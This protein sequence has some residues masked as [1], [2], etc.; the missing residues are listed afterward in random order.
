MLSISI[1]FALL[2]SFLTYI[3]IGYARKRNIIDIPN[4]RSSHTAPTPRGGGVSIVITF[5]LVVLYLVYTFS[6]EPTLNLWPLLLA[7]LLIAFIGF[8]DDNQHVKFQIRLAI[9][10][11]A[12]IGLVLAYGVPT[13]DLLGWVVDTK[14]LMVVFVILAIVWLT[15]LYNFMDGINGIASTEAISVLLVMG[16]LLTGVSSILSTLCFL[17]AFVIVGFLPWNFPRAKVFMGD[18]GSGF[19]GFILAALWLVSSIFD[20]RLFWCW[21]IMLGV[22]IVDSTIT[23]L[24]R[25]CSGKRI[26]EPHKSHAYQYF[27]RKLGTHYLITLLVLAINIMWCAPWSLMVFRDSV[28]GVVGLL[29]AYSPLALI[30]CF[31]H[32]KQK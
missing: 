3:F 2:S 5:I 1:L 18:S 16:Y 13:I 7:S 30:S 32:Y 29:V 4:A 12:T 23:L 14:A 11:I 8:W 22:F 26:F 31:A 20:H 25:L 19:L 10:F 6:Q 28:H 15:N 21:L 24:W 17:L 9:H 27:S